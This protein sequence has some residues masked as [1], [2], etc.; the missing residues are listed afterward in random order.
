MHRKGMACYWQ[1][2]DHMIFPIKWEFFQAVAV[3]E[4]LYGCTT[5]TLNNLK[6]L[7][8]NIKPEEILIFLKENNLF[9]KI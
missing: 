5:W 2:I 1:V 4:L 9:I 6:D 7:F 8:K 3:S